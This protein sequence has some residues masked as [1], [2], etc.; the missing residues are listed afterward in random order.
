MFVEKIQD[1]CTLVMDLDMK[2][3][4]KYEVRQYTRET[5]DEL[6]QFFI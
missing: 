1:T 5:I 2:Y 3:K 6:L 4:D